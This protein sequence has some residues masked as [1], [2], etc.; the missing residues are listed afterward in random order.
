MWAAATIIFS[1]F[2]KYNQLTVMKITKNALAEFLDVLVDWETAIVDKLLTNR[3]IK[4]I[5]AQKRTKYENATKCYIC[6]KAFEED[7]LTMPKTNDH[8]Y[9]T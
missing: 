8:D 4:R 5:S 6:G 3:P 2:G 1:T 7:D 9:I